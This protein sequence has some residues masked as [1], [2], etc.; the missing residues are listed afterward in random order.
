MSAYLCLADGLSDSALRGEAFN[1]SPESHWTVLQIVTLIQQLMGAADVSPQILN[2]AKSEIRSQYLSSE[3]AR[4]QL[5]WKPNF[6][7]EEGLTETIQWYREF[8]G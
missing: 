2:T 1:F 7:L 8:F 5:R 4:R 6:T 3:K